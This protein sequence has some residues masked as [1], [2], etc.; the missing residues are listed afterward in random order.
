M[1]QNWEAWSDRYEE[2][3]PVIGL[4]KHHLFYPTRVE[5]FLRDQIELMVLIKVKSDKGLIYGSIREFSKSDFSVKIQWMLNKEINKKLTYLNRFGGDIDIKKSVQAQKGEPHHVYVRGFK[6]KKTG[7]AYITYWFFYLENFVPRSNKDDKIAEVLKNDPNKWWTHEGDWE[8]I[9]VRFSDYQDSHPSEI[10]FSHHN[11]PHKRV[12]QNVPL[13]DD[14]ALVISA[15]GSHAN[16]FQPV[17]K[18]HAPVINL[19]EVAS[20]DILVFPDQIKKGNQLGYQ[21]EEFDPRKK[22]LWLHFKGRWG[23]SE[24]GLGMAPTGPLMKRRQ[25]FTLLADI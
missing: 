17:N 16:F 2:F 1:A 4:H 8:G 10:I 12:W 15:L 3:A 14:R 7:E 19:F 24:G 11:E 6:H 9:S 25:H 21:L 5:A 20:P 23:Q 18:R 13:Q 22:H